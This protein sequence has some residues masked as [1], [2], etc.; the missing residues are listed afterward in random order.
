MSRACLN[1]VFAAVMQTKSKNAVE[2]KSQD[3][4]FESKSKPGQLMCTNGSLPMIQ[5]RNWIFET[6]QQ[7]RD[8]DWYN[9]CAF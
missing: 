6:A 9:E 8:W 3:F 5:H 7:S 1:L 4:A 2:Q